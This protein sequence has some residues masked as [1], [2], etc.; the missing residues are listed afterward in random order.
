MKTKNQLEEEIK[1][2]L[3]EKENSK[4]TDL[5]NKKVK[6]ILLEK[7]E[8]TILEKF[9]VVLDSYSD[10]RIKKNKGKYKFEYTIHSGWSSFITDTLEEGIDRLI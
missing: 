5:K 1:E 6:K 4:R 3:W 9:E 2:M 8:L 7:L 10:I